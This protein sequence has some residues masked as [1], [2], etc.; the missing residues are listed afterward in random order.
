[1]DDTTVVIL[2]IILALVVFLIL[3]EVV[4]WYYKINRIVDILQSIEKKLSAASM[5]D[6]TPEST[7][8]A[9]ANAPSGRCPKCGAPLSP[10]ILAGTAVN[11]LECGHSFRAPG[12]V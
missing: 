9:S 1:M 10:G 8:A 6:P 7:R 5:L 3:R 12:E 4:C 2:G 11:C